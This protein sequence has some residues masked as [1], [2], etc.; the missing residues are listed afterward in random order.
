MRFKGRRHK[1][2]REDFATK[3]CLCIWETPAHSVTGHI[4]IEVSRIPPVPAI[5]VMRILS[6]SKNRNTLMMSRMYKQTAPTNM[7]LLSLLV[8]LLHSFQQQ[9]VHST[10]DC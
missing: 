7:F 5:M 8:I 10:G 9:L 3:T 6:F 4:S 2:V 1:S